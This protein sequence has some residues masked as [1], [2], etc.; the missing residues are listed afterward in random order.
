M[1]VCLIFVF[2]LSQFLVQNLLAQTLG[3]SST[4]SFLKLPHHPMTASLGGRNV[5]TFAGEA[6]LITENPSL[7]RE[8]NHGDIS[9]S[10]SFLS[11]GIMALTGSGIL[12]IKKIKT[13]FGLTIGHVEYG[14][15]DQTDASG[16][17]LGVFNPFDQFV[18]LSASRKYGSKWYYGSAMK[19]IHSSYGAFRS[20]ALVLDMGLNYFD[21]QK[22]IQ[23]GFAAKNM[24][25][26][27]KTYAGNGE[28]LPFDMLIGLTKQLEKAPF[29]FSIMAQRIHQFDLLYQDTS[30]NTGSVGEDKQSNFQ[31]KL[32]S[33]FI[34]GTEILISERLILLGGYNFL[35]SME[36]RLPSL[37]NGLSGFS[38]GINLK[39]PKFDFY[40]SRSNYQRSIAQN[41]IGITYKM[42][43][44]AD[45]K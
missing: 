15:I 33:H 30:F 37:S 29:R 4:Y 2:L 9:T 16:N 27:L 36:L 21:E 11:P 14:E 1:R 13:N 31:R 19:F 7:I 26:Q 22:K 28:D 17:I 24:G 8:S 38:Y 10:F 32:F 40:F 20:S 6:G 23:F 5:S 43:G 25:F 39:M 35:R 42:T 45:Q 34:L 18:Q 41:Q 44:K 12:R 3:G